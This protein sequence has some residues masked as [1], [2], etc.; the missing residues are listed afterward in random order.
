MTMDVQNYEYYE[1][2]A[3]GVAL[4][5]ITSDDNN[6]DI[7]ARLRDNNDPEF[8]VLSV[9]TNVAYEYDFDVS[10][11]NHLGWLGYFV[12]KSNQLETLNIE[13]TVPENINLNAFLEGLGRNRSIQD[14]TISINLGE[15]FQSLIPFV[16]NNARLRHLTFTDFDIGLQCA[17][18]IAMLLSQQCSLKCLG[19]E[20]TPFSSKGLKQITAALRSQ[21]QIEE[22]YVYDNCVGRNGYEALRNG[23]EGCLSLR[24]LEFIPGGP[25]NIDAEPID[26]ERFVAL[27]QGLKHCHN[28]TS[29]CLSGNLTVAEEGLRSLS[30]LLQSDNCRLEVL[31][32]GQVNIDDG[33]MAVLSTGLSSLTSLKRLNVWGMSIGDHGLQDL[34]RSLVNCN[35]EELSLSKS[36]LA[37][38]FSGLRALGTL[39]RRKTNIRSL[40]LIDTS[41]TD[42]GLQSFVEGMA[43]CCRLEEL[44][45]SNNDSITANG[46]TS[47]SSLL[48]AEHCSLRALVLNG[49]HLDDEGAAALAHGLVGNKSLTALEFSSSSFTARGWSAFSRL[50]CD[51]S[52]MSNTYLSNH[53]LQRVGDYGLDIPEDV[54]QYLKWNKS[55][56]HA[57]ALCKIL[58]SHPDVDITPLFQ[59]N[60]KCLPLVVEWLEKT[61]SYCEEVNESSEAF[62]CRQIS[63]VYKFIRGMPLLAACGYRSQTK[64]VQLQSSL[65]KREFFHL[66]L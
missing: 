52:S 59:F 63:T 41:L 30:A 62:Q 18:N 47:L 43:N 64:G 23:L 14:L 9:T 8:K 55:L 26:D 22:L 24:K 2:R 21:S 33:G 38:S 37:E 60:L 1:A 66:T 40:C 35:L 27:T 65:K 6:A 53:T 42:A 29:F 19:F 46:L 58:R 10:E 51:T 57:A 25:G 48:R 31:A 17:R 54:A 11:G 16:K 45:L 28:L 50:L 12:G 7:L 20:D 44:Y 39:C 15:S 3:K 36:M 32:L 34:V 5:Y 56:K 13:Q 49:V 4:E 61:K